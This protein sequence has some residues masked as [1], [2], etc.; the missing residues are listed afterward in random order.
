MRSVK[1]QSGGDRRTGKS[2]ASRRETGA[3]TYVQ[4]P[5]LSSDTD[6]EVLD[7]NPYEFVLR[8]CQDLWANVKLQAFSDW[9]AETT[10]TL[11]RIMLTSVSFL[12]DCSIPELSLIKMA[13]RLA[14]PSSFVPLHHVEG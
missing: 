12:G 8:Q 3:S 11:E 10:S 4:L 7:P 5:A 2:G 9:R 1:E 14:Y 13:S 6:L